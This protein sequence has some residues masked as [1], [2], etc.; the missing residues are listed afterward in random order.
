M[1]TTLLATTASLAD[2]F[3]PAG[4]KEPLATFQQRQKHPAKNGTRQPCGNKVSR[5]QLTAASLVYLE[6][7]NRGYLVPL[8]EITVI[9]A[10]H[11]R[12]K[13]HFNDH[14]VVLSSSLQ[15]LE[16]RL[17]AGLFIRANRAQI[18]N[19]SFVE[20]A[21]PLPDGTLQLVLQDRLSTSIVL[22]RRQAALFKQKWGL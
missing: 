22:S 6:T 5:R 15:Y 1:Q 12:T 9:E 10:D 17:P 4:K 11:K 2:P 3:I 21:N 8:A 20:T 19:T 16:N 7:T 18:V 13:V 14:S